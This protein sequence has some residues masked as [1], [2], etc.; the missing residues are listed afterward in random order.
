MSRSIKV[1]SNC[2]K[3]WLGRCARPLLNTDGGWVDRLRRKKE[4]GRRKKEEG[5]RKEP[6]LTRAPPR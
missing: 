5:R 1:S 4:K 2:R 3:N 6:N